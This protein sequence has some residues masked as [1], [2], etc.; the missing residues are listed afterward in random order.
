MKQ[1][2]IGMTA[3]AVNLVLFSCTKAPIPTEPV[4]ETSVTEA[5]HVKTKSKVAM[6]V[7][8]YDPNKQSIYRIQLLKADNGYQPILIDSVVLNFKK[9]N[10]PNFDGKDT[11][12]R[13]KSEDDM[14]MPLS[15]NGVTRYLRHNAYVLPNQRL[16]TKW[17]FDSTLFRITHLSNMR[18]ILRITALN[19]PNEGKEYIVDKSRYTN[20]PLHFIAKEGVTEHWFSLE[21]DQDSNVYTKIYLKYFRS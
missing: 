16:E 4:E 13:L 8:P 18:Y 6:R 11:L 10:T 7:T 3:I 9:Y 14:M 20:N 2:K 5:G 21:T 15:Q 12:N 17:V 1:L 19:M